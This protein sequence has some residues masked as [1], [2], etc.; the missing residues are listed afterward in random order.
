MQHDLVHNENRNLTN[1]TLQLQKFIKRSNLTKFKSHHEVE[2]RIF[3]YVTQL[4]IFFY[5]GPS[6]EYVVGFFRSQ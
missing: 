2:K 4:K 5:D 3:C 6:I 1:E